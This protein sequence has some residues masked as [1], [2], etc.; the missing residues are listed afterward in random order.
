MSAILNFIKKLIFPNT[1]SSDAYI[2]YLKKMGVKVGKNC[3]VFEPDTVSLDCARPYLLELGDNV[4]ITKGVTVLTHDYSHTVIRKKYGMQYGDAKDVKIGNN[5]F[6]GR[7]S[8]VLMGT[9]IGDNVIVAAKSVVRGKIPSDVVVAGNPAT[10]VC[11]IEEFCEG[12]KKRELECAKKNVQLCME[13]LQR[14]PTIY[15]MG[16][17]FAWLYLPRTQ[18]SIDQYPQFFNLPGD[19][20]DDLID[21]FLK[22]KPMFESYEQFL[23]WVKNSG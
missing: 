7:D 9:T 1:Y 8:I 2:N 17:A 22:S 4:V 23:D 18:E 5:V 6:L 10:V 3:H 19:D 11:T 16:D 15:E 20:S 12:R 14:Y 13:R 21:N